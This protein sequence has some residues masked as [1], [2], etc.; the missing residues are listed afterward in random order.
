MQAFYSK[1]AFCLFRRGMG[2]ML[3]LFLR[4]WAICTTMRRFYSR[5]CGNRA[6]AVQNSGEINVPHSPGEYRLPASGRRHI[7]WEW[8]MHSIILAQLL[9]DG[10]SNQKGYLRSNL[11][12]AIRAASRLC[13][14]KLVRCLSPELKLSH[15]MSSKSV[16]VDFPINTCQNRR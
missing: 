5:K 8:S 1:A 2:R 14:R 15:A 4:K 13:R 12:C 16:N 9:R 11:I 6:K 3:L 10:I 7:L